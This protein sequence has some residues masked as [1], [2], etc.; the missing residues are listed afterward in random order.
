MG[1]ALVEPEARGV[2][3]TGTVR[4]KATEN[5]VS[6]NFFGICYKKYAMF[7]ASFTFHFHEAETNI[8]FS[9]VI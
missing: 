2:A 8:P 1:C 9:V 4:P 7:R 5:G 6:R 3:L